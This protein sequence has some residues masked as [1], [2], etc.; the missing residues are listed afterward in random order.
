M[1]KCWIPYVENLKTSVNI[2]RIRQQLLGRWSAETKL[3]EQTA[4]DLF[5]LNLSD[6]WQKFPHI[7]FTHLLLSCNLLTQEEIMNAEWVFITDSFLQ[8]KR[9]ARD[10]GRSIVSSSNIAQRER[11]DL[12]LSIDDYE[13]FPEH[14]SSLVYWKTPCRPTND[15]RPMISV[16]IAGMTTGHIQA[17]LRKNFKERERCMDSITARIMEREVERRQN[18]SVRKDM[19]RRLKEEE[20]KRCEEQS[21]IK[22]DASHMKNELEEIT[23]KFVEDVRR[24]SAF[25]AVQFELFVG[26]NEHWAEFKYKTAAHLKRDGISMRNL[27]GEWIK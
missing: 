18:E 6:E 4:F 25:N 15:N 10:W 3:K 20:K 5:L 14:E 19:Q 21:S 13:W 11:L 8:S 27:K 7:K 9:F 16:P 12:F 2:E 1:T 23:V 24:L 22:G 26:T 17:C